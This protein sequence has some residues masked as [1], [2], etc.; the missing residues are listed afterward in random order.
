MKM[1]RSP[2]YWDRNFALY[3][4]GSFASALGSTLSNFCTGLFYLDMTGSAALMS[5]YIAWTTALSLVLTPLMGAVCDRLPKVKVL[6]VCDFLFAATDLV[7]AA[8]LFSGL[9]GT[10]ATTVVFINGTINCLIGTL[11]TPAANSMV[12]LL[13]S[14]AHLTA[15][16]SLLSTRSNIVNLLGVPL[17]AALYSTA[18]YPVILLLNG[19]LVGVSGLFEMFIHLQQPPS[20]FKPVRL[21]QDWK[22]GLQYML[23]IRLLVVLGLIA[24]PANFLLTG[25]FSITMPYMINTEFRLDP[26]VLAICE[27]GIPIGSILA[28]AWLGTRKH[29]RAGQMIPIAFG[30]ITV[31]LTA[32]YGAYLLVAGGTISEQTFIC[33]IVPLFILV[34]A[35]MTIANIPLDALKSSLIAPEYMG[36]VTSLFNTVCSAA[37]P[38]AA[39]TYGFILDKAGLGAACAVSAAGIALCLLVVLSQRRHFDHQ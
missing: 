7:V 31:T 37:T 30:A 8:L 20:E 21:W 29:V 14:K 6:W 2:A 26:M 3:F 36:R 22:E 18:G 15:A 39:I 28:A 19:I 38:L 25:V 24:L 5:L 33:M 1:H 17:A 32:L 9:S 27:V 10:A 35:G 4:G 16:Y 13:V 34:A 12:P 23:R 11:F